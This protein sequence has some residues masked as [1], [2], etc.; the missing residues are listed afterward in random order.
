MI[1][2]AT[3]ER[4]VAV[5]PLGDTVSEITPLAKGFSTDDK[6]ILTVNA[7]PTY[8]L[9][10]SHER[11]TERRRTEFS[12]LT[13]LAARGISCSK[14]H[15]FGSAPEFGVCVSLLSYLP[16]TCAE[17]ALP[18]MDAA[19][20]Y[21]IGV[22]AGETLKRMYAALAVPTDI[23]WPVYRMGKYRRFL[24][25]AQEHG[26]RF[27]NQEVVEQFVDAHHHLV[28]GRPVTFLH[29]DFHPGNLIIVAGQYSGVIDFNRCDWGDPYH[30]FYKLAHFS[31]P[32]FPAFA[33]G[34]V[35]G[36]F[37]G[38]VPTDFWPLYTLYVAMSLHVDL[39]WTQRF[40]LD[41]LDASY[42]RIAQICQT[43]DF[44]KGAA[45]NWYCQ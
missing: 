33:R 7:E 25:I 42:Q 18:A 15:Y 27:L 24:G 29:D 23:N 17:E 14:P 40:W 2:I 20:Q 19:I 44:I 45:P 6:F 16:G 3:V 31:A 39:A 8:L 10:I 26:L 30:D 36:Y 32:E 4:I 34:Q 22:K 9:R 28:Q 43:H 11:E 21:P 37:G 12:L 5:I 13:Q 1:D 35:D 41:R 38:E